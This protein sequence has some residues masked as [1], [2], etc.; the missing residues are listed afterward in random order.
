MSDWYN[1]TSWGIL[2][3]PE[4]PAV[5]LEELWMRKERNLIIY[6][7]VEN[8]VSGDPDYDFDEWEVENEEDD[9]A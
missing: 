4:P 2:D 7:S 8:G 1:A 6:N 9:G 3:Y 5:T